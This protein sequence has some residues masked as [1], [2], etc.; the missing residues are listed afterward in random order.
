MDKKDLRKIQQFL[1]IESPKED[2]N[3]NVSEEDF[4]KQNF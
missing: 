4:W 2:K 3:T 1:K